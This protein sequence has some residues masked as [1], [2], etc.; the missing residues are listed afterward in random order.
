M[1]AF[2]QA[3]T[4]SKLGNLLFK[5][6]FTTKQKRLTKVSLFSGADEGT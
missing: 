2:R 1:P 3:L 6:L 4:C 5:S